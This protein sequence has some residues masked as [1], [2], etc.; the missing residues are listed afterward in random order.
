MQYSYAFSPSYSC[1]ATNEVGSVEHK[2][3]VSVIGPVFV[4]PMPNITA[5][6]GQTVNIDCP[7]TGHPIESIVWLKRQ[8]DGYTGKVPQNHR[9]KVYANGTLSISGVSANEDQHWYRCSVNGSTT[10]AH[11]DLNLRVIVAPVIGPI[12]VPKVLREGMRVMLT[13]A[14]L[15][16]DPPLDIVFMREQ[17]PVHQ[18]R[19]IRIEANNEFSRTLFISEVSEEDSGDYQCIASNSAAKTVSLFRLDVQGM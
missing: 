9:Q 15:E 18:N 14:V 4:R 3:R 12:P 19:R 11:S 5:I 17:I 1:T 16:G 6:A 8:N 7:F 13:C 10:S 2:S